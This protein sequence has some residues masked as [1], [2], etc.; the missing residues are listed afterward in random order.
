MNKIS[1]TKGKSFIVEIKKENNLVIR[2][3]EEDIKKFINILKNKGIKIKNLK[4]Y[5]CL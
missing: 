2:G 4:I 5:P 1:R 3:G